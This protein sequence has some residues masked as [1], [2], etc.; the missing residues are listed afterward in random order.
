VIYLDTSA[1]VKL[2][3]REP[4]SDA[5]RDYYTE[6]PAAA[7]SM[8][9]RT[10][11]R[12]AVRRVRPDLLAEGDELLRIVAPVAV[13][14]ALLDTAGA[15]LPETLR[16]LDAIHLASALVIR[17]ELE[18]FVSYDTRLLEAAQALGLRTERPE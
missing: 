7:T 1:L 6:H 17:S 14:G 3:V 12:R 5:L 2:V 15:L 13:T 16:S 8:L 10:E 9:T 18:A 11:L 4:E